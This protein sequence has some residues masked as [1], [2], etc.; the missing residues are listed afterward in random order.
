[1]NNTTINFPDNLQKWHLIWNCFISYRLHRKKIVQQILRQ[2]NNQ[3]DTKRTTNLCIMYLSHRISWATQCSIWSSTLYI[4]YNNMEDIGFGQINVKN[5]SGFVRFFYR[6]LLVAYFVY[7]IQTKRRPIFITFWQN[8]LIHKFS[9]CFGWNRT[10]W[11]DGS[12]VSPNRAKKL[13]T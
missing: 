10:K 12:E 13:G 5:F 9:S 2:R 1:M 3:D 8:M 11:K 7:T 6:S 4:V